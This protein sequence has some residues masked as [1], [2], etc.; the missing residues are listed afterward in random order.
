MS[1]AAAAPRSWLLQPRKAS[2]GPWSWLLPGVA[3]ALQWLLETGLKRGARVGL[4][5]ANTPATAALLQAAPLAGMTLVLLNRRLALVEAE[6]QAGSARLDALAADAAHPLARLATLRLPEAFVDGA[7]PGIE[8][9]APEDPALVL[10]TSGTSGA[11]KAARLP[12]R[13]LLAAA[14]AAR[15]R[16]SLSER[17]TWLGCLPLEH[18]GGA[19][20]AFRSGRCGHAVL[21]LERFEVD[22]ADIAI[23]R[24]TGASLVPTMLHRLV[25]R[26][27]ERRWP[28]TLRTLLIGGG[29]LTPAL[30]ARSAALGREPCQTYGLTE[31]ASQVCTLA[32]A[33]A[34]MHRGTAGRALDG[35]ELAIRRSDGSPAESGEIGAIHVRGSNLFSGYERSGDL[36]EGIAPGSWFATGDLGER[37]SA[38]Y[39]TVHCRREDLI[40]SGGENVYPLEVEAALAEH[41][42]VREAAVC[43]LPDEEWGQVVAAA[44]VASGPAPSEAELASWL[45][46]R[47]A[48]FKR[49]R[50][51]RWLPDLPRS[52]GGKLLRARLPE[53]FNLR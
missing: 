26:R 7:L 47:L 3:G 6:R 25:E 42:A 41:P 43:G 11:P 52:P 18:I 15:A 32:P 40:L 16:L 2:V 30:C 48:P 46:E 29:P 51:W 20:L 24:A 19:S 34:A 44:L 1:D 23:E 21:L 27:G 37:D 28:A 17:D 49:P 13:A 10:F 14:D 35:M 5:G 9:L 31:C 22:A 12:L 53:L 38:G 50:R 33:E 4:A 39:L 45:A 8:P 36:A